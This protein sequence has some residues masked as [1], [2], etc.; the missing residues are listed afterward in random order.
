MGVH[1]VLKQWI[2][3]YM[4]LA[5]SYPCMKK[6][7]TIYWYTSLVYTVFTHN[8]PINI[9]S[10]FGTPDQYLFCLLVYLTNI[11][12]FFILHLILLFLR[13]YVG[14]IFAIHVYLVCSN[15]KFYRWGI[16]QPVTLESCLYLT[17]FVDIKRLQA[18]TGPKHEFITSNQVILYLEKGTQK[19]R[20]P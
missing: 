20:V 13:I 17:I 6:K 4:L 9:I 5:N 15:D 11:F 10:Y 18:Q 8:S 7:Q 16:Y 1:T 3:H 12:S 2:Q 19:S 14:Y